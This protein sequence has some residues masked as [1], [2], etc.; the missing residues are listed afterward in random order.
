[1]GAAAPVLGRAPAIFLLTSRPWAASL[2]SS[3][4]PPS[5]ARLSLFPA[6]ADGGQTS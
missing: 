2:P 1:M 6:L 4:F 3:P 5:S